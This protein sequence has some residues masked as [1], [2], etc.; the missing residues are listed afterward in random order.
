MK[1]N[2]ITCDEYEVDATEKNEAIRKGELEFASEHNHS[3]YDAIAINGK[4]E[5]DL[6]PLGEKSIFE[7]TRYVL[8]CTYNF[9]AGYV[10]RPF[11]SLKSAKKAL[12]E[13][14]KTEFKTIQKERGYNPTVINCTD[15]GDGETDIVLV[16]EEN[17]SFDVI[18]GRKVFY[19]DILRYQIFEVE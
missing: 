18:N 12:S 8:I 15:A 19:T 14:L 17:A 6:T 10:C 2:F 9:D 16:Y 5:K 11:S 13:D 3:L 1:V 4:I 7:K